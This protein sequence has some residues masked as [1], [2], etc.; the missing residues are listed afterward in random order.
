MS[1]HDTD[2]YAWTYETAAKLRQGK[3]NEVDMNQIAEE[4][5]EMGRSER[6][7]LENR[8]AVLLAHLLKWQYQPDRRGNSWRLTIDEQRV[9]IRR[10]L[11][12]N[13]SLKP[14]LAESASEAYLI[15]IPQAA[16]ETHLAKNTFPPTFEQ[17]N[18]MVEQVLDDEFY[19]ES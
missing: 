13:P 15:A 14:K 8:L 12:Q 7:E 3:F 11:K 10:V 5:E 9:R 1:T 4:L 16:R 18:W 2:Y 17:T 19:P 6:H